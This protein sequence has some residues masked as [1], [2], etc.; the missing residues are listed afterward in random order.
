MRFEDR[1]LTGAETDREIEQERQSELERDDERELP[2][3]QP[4]EVLDD[5][6]EH[7]VIDAMRSILDHR[8][9]VINDLALPK[10]ELDALEALKTAVEAKDG[11]LNRFVYA[12][13]RQEL[14]EQALAVLQPKLAQDRALFGELLAKVSE[15]RCDLR[16]L[17][18]AEDELLVTE[19]KAVKLVD[20][21]EDDDDTPKESTLSNGPEVKVADAK[22]TLSDGPEAKLADAKSTLADGPA[23]P[24]LEQGPTTLGDLG[25]IKAAEKPWWRS[26]P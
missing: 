15:L 7:R 24:E 12:S 14:L 6:S 26:K 13:D 17:E 9:F 11:Q 20:A 16:R 18:D 21:T 4:L 3:I 25:E 23:A 2:A 5:K 22:S 10:R 1:E 19:V 8:S